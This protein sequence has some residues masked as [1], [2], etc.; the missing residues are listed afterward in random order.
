MKSKLIYIFCAAF[1]VYVEIMFDWNEGPALIAAMMIFPV[2]CLLLAFSLKR[3]LKLTVGAD[4]QTVECGDDIRVYIHVDNK[5]PLPAACVKVRLV[6]SYAGSGY[7]EKKT[8][9]LTGAPG[10]RSDIRCTMREVFCGR[11]EVKVASAR[12]YDYF[13]LFSFRLKAAEE[14][15]IAVLPRPV[16]IYPQVSD[17]VRLFPIDSEEYSRLHSGDDPSEVFDVRE[18]RPGDKMSSVHWKLSARGDDLLVKEYSLSVGAPVVL[19]MTGS[20]LAI[21][22]RVR[23]A[24]IVAAVSIS[25]GLLREECSHYA[26]CKEGDGDWMRLRISDEES[27]YKLVFTALSFMERM[28]EEAD[29]EAYRQSFPIERYCTFLKLSADLM[30]EVNGQPIAEIDCNNLE[31]SLKNIE[32]YI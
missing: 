31:T 18:Y 30:L 21:E 22:P 9:I 20:A 13:R 3:A 1:A 15:V 23:Q 5:S 32:L 7:E 24:W 4:R 11:V 12:V 2:L 27:F 17:K 26:V 19:L 16:E 29:E 8:V 6:C 28:P 10:C 25:Y 14:L